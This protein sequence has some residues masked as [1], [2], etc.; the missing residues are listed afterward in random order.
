[1]AASSSCCLDS[2]VQ[3]KWEKFNK[4]RFSLLFHFIIMEWLK[5]TICFNTYNESYRRPHSLTCG[6]SFCERCLNNT[7][8]NDTLTCPQCRKIHEIKSAM[9]LPINFP[10]E[11]LLKTLNTCSQ[12]ERKEAISSPI[13]RECNINGKSETHSSL[14]S[15][16]EQQERSLSEQKKLLKISA[17]MCIEHPSKECM[18]RCSL[19]LCWVCEECIEEQGDHPKHK[20]KIT[21][22]KEE[23]E[24]RRQEHKMSLEDEGKTCDETLIVIEKHI[25]YLRDKKERH[26]SLV[27][28]LQDLVK[29]H[30]NEEENLQ[31][32]ITSFK[33]NIEKGKSVKQMLLDDEAT[34]MNAATLDESNA[35][36]ARMKKKK[37]EARHWV[38]SSQR[39]VN[40]G[41]VKIEESTSPAMETWLTLYQE[42]ERE[43]S[44]SGQIETITNKKK[45]EDIEFAR[46]KI[47][48]SEN[49]DP[50]RVE[51]RRKIPGGGLFYSCLQ[52][53]TDD[54][55]ILC[56]SC[57]VNSGHLNHKTEIRYVSQCG[58]CDCGISEVWKSEPTCST[59]LR[60][61]NNPVKAF[62][63]EMLLSSKCKKIF[64]KGEKCYIC[65]DCTALSTTIICGTCFLNSSHKDHRFAIILIRGDG[66]FCGCGI[67]EGW[68][69]DHTCEI[70]K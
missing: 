31:I 9:D 4:I 2:P 19:H 54:S 16:L 35:V 67:I 55:V 7:I 10:L 32:E 60:K 20:C 26:T 68:N 70:H 57:F 23:I 29:T 45:S 28:I 58:Y 64:Y 8:Q 69:S 38:N 39:E 24:A 49:N 30:K 1:A 62:S 41:K 13:E 14:K 56:G 44:K 61:D 48:S 6:H 65:Q 37:A 15:L 66:A 27:N 40:E 47:I 25:S 34:I 52:C 46:N 33:K 36:R 51:C 18:F 43:V 5:C 21:S 3:F 59:H 42:L 12:D 50:Q 11:G 22:F 63:E 53:R 17:G